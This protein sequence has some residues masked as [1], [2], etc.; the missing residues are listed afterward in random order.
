MN[1]TS[2]LPTRNSAAVGPYTWPLPADRAARKAL[3]RD[4][5]ARRNL[6]RAEAREQ[7]RERRRRVWASADS[8][9][10]FAARMG[11]PVWGAVLVS[12]A[13]GGFL[14]VIVGLA[15]HALQ[16]A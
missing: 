15:V 7:V 13:M 10:T 11:L 3:H 14:G 4:L 5:S 8:I 6:R 1:T 12:I 2:T 9:P 16:S